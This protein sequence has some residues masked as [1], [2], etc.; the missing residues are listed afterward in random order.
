MVRRVLR[1]CRD[2]SDSERASNV[3]C[4]HENINYIRMLQLTYYQLS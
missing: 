3:R 4:P 2:S 1:W